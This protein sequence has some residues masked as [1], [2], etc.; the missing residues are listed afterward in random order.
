MGLKEEW[1][2]AG[3]TFRSGAGNGMAG[4]VRPG[5]GP[6]EGG[7]GPHG[8]S[9]GPRPDNDA[10]TTE[11]VMTSKLEPYGGCGEAPY[12]AMTTKSGHDFEA[13][14]VRSLS[15]ASVRL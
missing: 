7:T 12:D 1:L 11:S 4:G 13:R 3:R 5:G 10:M 6:T 15:R 8:C 2:G 9:L 14:A